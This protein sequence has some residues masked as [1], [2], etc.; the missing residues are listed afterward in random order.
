MAPQHSNRNPKPVKID[1]A[2]NPAEIALLPERDLD[3]TTCVAFDILRATSSMITA[4]ANGTRAIHPVPT[5]GDAL[6]LKDKFPDAVLGGER[7]GERIEGFQLGNSP[8]EYRDNPPARIVTTTTNGTVALRACDHARETLV[9][10]LLNLDAIRRRI[11]DRPSVLLVCAGTFETLAAED[12]LAAGMLC[13]EFPDATLTDSADVAL[14]YSTLC[15]GDLGGALRRTRNGAAL[16]EKCRG[17]EIDWCAQR[18]L[19]D[20]VGVLRNGVVAA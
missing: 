6:S 19:Y 11:T 15:R 16:L 8:L 18:S 10:A 2:L 9:G 7:H 17:A 14:R 1:V 13:A 5:I 12:V 4:L 3:R 20:T